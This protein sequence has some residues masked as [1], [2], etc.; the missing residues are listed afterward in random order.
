M[1]FKQL[2]QEKLSTQG[3]IPLELIPLAPRGFQELNK[4]VILNLN[5]DLEPYAKEIATAI[6]ELFPRMKGFWLRKGQIEGKFRQ[7]QGL[8]H[9]LGDTETELIITEN[10]VRYKFDFTKIMFAKG[11]IHERNLLPKKI[12]NPMK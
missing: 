1:G 7:P 10:G 3:K 6:L 4:R 11:N 12:L 5:A 9:I 2:L 8:V